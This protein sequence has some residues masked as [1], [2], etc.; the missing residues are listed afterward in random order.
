MRLF[1]HTLFSMNKKKAKVI[2][3]SFFL[4]RETEIVQTERDHALYRHFELAH[5]S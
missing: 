3:V 1:V 5:K 2:I 4:H